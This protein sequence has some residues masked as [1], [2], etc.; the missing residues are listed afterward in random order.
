M[1]T[2]SRLEMGG[3][4]SSKFKINFESDFN[5]KIMNIGI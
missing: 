2:Q 4:L 1:A 3:K 5:Y